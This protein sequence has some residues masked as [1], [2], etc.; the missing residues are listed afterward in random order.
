MPEPTAYNGRDQP[1]AESPP[2][3]KAP[4]NPRW[5][6]GP[7]PYKKT[8]WPKTKDMMYIPSSSDS[9]GGVSFRSNSNGDPE[10][11]I[12]KLT[13]WN[14]DWLPAPETWSARK[15]HADR[16]F[17][18]HIAQWAQAIPREC[19]IQVYLPPNTFTLSKEVAPRYWLEVKIEGD[20]LRENWQKLVTTKS[21]PELVD[22]NDVVDYL[23]WWE[24]YEDVIY[25]ETI[26][27]SD[28]RDQKRLTHASSY[29]HA[30]PVPDARVDF[31]DEERPST[32]YLLASTEAKVQAIN[33]RVEA[34][35]R[36]TM[37][38]RSRPIPES[39]LP[40]QQMVDRRLRPEANIC[41]RPIQASDV[42]GIT[43]SQSS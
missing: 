34:K 6:R 5:P 15:G 31:E 2:I 20:N 43:V 17:G 26:D 29:L 1:K 37:A 36:K 18:A 24:L 19:H 21:E 10:Y 9:D 25:E 8:V 23:P 30:L 3:T 14:G 27:A 16:H 41:I 33:K 28:N 35:H 39:K 42:L 7:Q 4:G 38:K 11:D 22:E 32:P 40:V 13:D 12:K